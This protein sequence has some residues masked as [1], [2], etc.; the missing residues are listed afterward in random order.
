MCQN[1]EI[2]NFERKAP[3]E[4]QVLGMAQR[5]AGH[6]PFCRLYPRALLPTLSVGFLPGLEEGPQG[7]PVLEALPSD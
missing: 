2:L 1:W 3:S 5:P 7:F 6:H 4:V